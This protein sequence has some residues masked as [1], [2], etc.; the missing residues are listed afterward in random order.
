MRT[1]PCEVCAAPIGR[2]DGR[3]SKRCVPCKKRPPRCPPHL[4][5]DYPDPPLNLTSQCRRC[6][7]RYPYDRAGISGTVAPV[8]RPWYGKGRTTYWNHY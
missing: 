1:V 3:S 7:N 5:H 2:K 4:Q 8:T 6:G